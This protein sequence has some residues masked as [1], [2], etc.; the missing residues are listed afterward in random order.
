MN[1]AKKIK[2]LLRNKENKVLVDLVETDCW[3]GDR[4]LKT[5]KTYGE[6]NR[7]EILWKQ[8]LKE[9]YGPSVDFMMDIPSLVFYLY[10]V[11]KEGEQVYREIFH[12]K[13]D[14]K[15]FLIG[16]FDGIKKDKQ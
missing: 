10:I 6:L 4:T 14:V 13:K 12:N 7:E 5:T 9:H 3:G 11:N 1:K 8:S 2:K 15:D 16:G